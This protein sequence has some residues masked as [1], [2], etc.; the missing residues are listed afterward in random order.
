MILLDTPSLI[1]WVSR[2][3]ALSTAA[4][5]GHRARAPGRRDPAL[6]RLGLGDR[7][8]DGAKTPGPAHGAPAWL[9]LVAAIPEARFIPVDHDIALQA[10][11][12]PGTPPAATAAR[13][14][15]ATARHC[16]CALVTPDPTLRGYAS[17][18]SIW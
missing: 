1:W 11:S 8:A 5:G 10:A 15:A 14:L 7:P 16:G 17:L 4:L 6:L 9:G 12:L 13:L 3:S 18:R 2:A